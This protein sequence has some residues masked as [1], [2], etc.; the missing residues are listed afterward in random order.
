[1]SDREA[2]LQRLVLAGLAGPPVINGCSLAGLSSM[3]VEQLLRIE[4]KLP[5]GQL[6][7]AIGHAQ[8]ML[9]ADALHD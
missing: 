7:I 4:L 3:C 2:L 9:K 5:C 6:Q 8:P 1:M